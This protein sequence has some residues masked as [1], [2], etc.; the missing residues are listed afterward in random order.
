M[1]VDPWMPFIQQSEQANLTICYYELPTIQRMNWFSQRFIN[2]DMRAGIPNP[3]TRQRTIT[4][5]L[6]KDSFRRE[7]AI[8]GEE[9]ITVLSVNQ[10]GVV[11]WYS[12]GP[13]TE[14]KARSL[15]NLL[16]EHL[17]T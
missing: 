15:E 7:L 17:S 4:L 8:T 1:E 10:T 3:K 9:P 5:Y 13:Y 6:N 14:E 2:E 12:T 11:L 16:S